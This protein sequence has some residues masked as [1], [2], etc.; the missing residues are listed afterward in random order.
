MPMVPPATLEGFADSLLLAAGASDFNAA[1]VSKSL[2]DA[3][4]AGH[5][6]HGVQKI[7]S[8]VRDIRSGS[9][10]P[11]ARPE[12]VH[13]RQA[14]AVI[15]GM[16]TFGHAGA[17]LSVEVA[18][19]KALEIGIAAVA[20]RRCHHT[21]RL[22][23]WVER[24][25]DAR[26]VG[27]MLGA[28]AHPPYKVAPFGGKQ[29]ALATNPVAW[30]IPRAPG[31]PP[32]LL[33]YATSVL[34]IGKLQLAR[35]RGDRLGEGCIV[36]ASG[37]PSRA[38]DDFFDGGA[39]LPFGGHKGYALGVIAELLAIGLGGGDRISKD[40]RGSTLFTIAFDPKLF[41][42]P[43]DF[44][45]FIRSTVERLKST[46]P[47]RGIAEVLVPGEPESRSRAL[48]SAGIPISEGTWQALTELGRNLGVV[49]PAL[50][51]DG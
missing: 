29:G 35:E 51:T 23:R 1:L 43:D 18:A 17:S 34:S 2:V 10:I 11:D 24:L 7:P 40:E 26:L 9:L 6:S 31:Q 32:I 38:V 20:T 4:L 37:E 3:N 5:D 15:D 25:A 44:E 12:V 21:G 41:R 27:V 45:S 49:V 42:L 8:Y 50:G 22:G 30:A 28:E 33:D 39:L 47:A 19:D 16:G 48:R 14:I 13:E 46:E 36:D